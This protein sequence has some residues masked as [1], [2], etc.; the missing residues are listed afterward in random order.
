VKTVNR[1]ALIEGF[2]P[3]IA[4]VLGNM[5]NCADPKGPV[6]IG[7]QSGMGLGKSHIVDNAPDFLFPNDPDVLVLKVTYNF[8]Q[9][10][11]F[12]GRQEYSGEG[13][14]A[15]LVIALHKQVPP[16]AYD[17]VKKALIIPGA[18]IT[19]A[20]VAK[21]ILA[22][23]K[24]SKIIVA[25]DEI[26]SVS[27]SVDAVRAVMSAIANFVVEVHTQSQGQQVAIGLVTALPATDLQSLSQRQPKLFSP[28]RL[29][30]E[31]AARLLSQLLPAASDNAIQL[32]QLVCGGHPRSL[33]VA[34][35][36][37]NARD[38][39]PPDLR[40]LASD[41]MWKAAQGQTADVIADG[42]CEAYEIG[43]KRINSKTPAMEIL[44]RSAMMMWNGERYSIAPTVLFSDCSL[45][46]TDDLKFVRSIFEVPPRP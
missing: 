14:L 31:E 32:L 9:A 21:H 10:L 26:A 15:R 6:L 8:H 30:D 40:H 3:L 13:L 25:V 44:N 43:D 17:V 1:D 46:A 5:S 24:C 7:V 33:A 42:I 39:N 11:G 18:L 41:C 35:Q 28:T 22:H 34:A 16:N 45:T 38:G 37:M 29:T 12:E 23:T 2:K 36:L 19:A 20:V 4:A 27:E